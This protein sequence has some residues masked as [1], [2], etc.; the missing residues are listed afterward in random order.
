MRPQ[1]DQLTPNDKQLKIHKELELGLFKQA[2]NEIKPAKSQF[3]E[4]KQRFEQ[5]L[6]DELKRNGPD[7]DQLRK[8]SSKD[9]ELQMMRKITLDND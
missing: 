7:K 3:D 6:H 1:D 2:A 8:Q 5:R 4:K 9:E